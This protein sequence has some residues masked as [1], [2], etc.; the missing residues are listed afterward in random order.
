MPDELYL[1]FSRTGNRDHYQ[2]KLSDRRN[3]MATL[4]LAECLENDGRFLPA[5]E[6]GGSRRASK[7]RAGSLPRHDGKLDNFHGKTVERSPGFLGHAA[8]L[9]TI[10][11]WLGSRLST[12]ARARLHRELRRGASS[13]RS[14]AWSGTTSRECG[15]FQPL[16]NWNAV[17]L[18]GVTIAATAAIDDR[19]ER[20]F[21]VASAEKYLRNF[22]DGF[23]ADGYCSEG[24]G[25]WN[26]G[27]GHF[28]L[29]AED[30]DQATGGKL[31]LLREPKVKVIARFAR[32]LE[33]LPGVYPAFADC[34]ID[35]HPEPWIMALVN[36]RFGFGWTDVE[37]ARVCPS[38]SAAI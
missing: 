24:L 25:Y 29:L 33:I 6:R 22:L 21:F 19:R 9:A 20:A 36:R 38:A 1:D 31:D 27:F 7:R 8:T 17:C 26:Y 37:S 4:V 30:I 34:H 32:M 15:G 3:R 16:N 5:I 18:S 28:L 13:I 12:K 23:T 35:A 14:R 2:R 11:F 10:D